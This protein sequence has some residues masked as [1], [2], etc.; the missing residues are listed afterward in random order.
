MPASSVTEFEKDF[1]TANFCCMSNKTDKNHESKKT[2][3]LH[4]QVEEDSLQ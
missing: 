1:R 4:L 3:N 2:Y